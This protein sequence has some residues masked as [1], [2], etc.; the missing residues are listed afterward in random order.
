MQMIIF[1][2]G[3]LIYCCFYLSYSSYRIGE[4]LDEASGIHKNEKAILP[5]GTTAEPKQIVSSW[6]RQKDKTVKVKRS[7]VKIKPQLIFKDKTDNTSIPFVPKLS[8][9]VRR[10][11]IK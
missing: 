1:L 5:D 6:N 10:I 9:K 4:R 2:K 3:Q 8:A 11:L 7:V